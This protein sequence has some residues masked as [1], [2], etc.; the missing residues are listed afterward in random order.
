MTT[1]NTLPI[2]QKDSLIIKVLE[3]QIIRFIVGIKGKGPGIRMETGDHKK[4]ASWGRKRTAQ[5]YREKQKQLIA[6]GKFKEAQQMDIDDIHEKFGHK[7]D[8]AISEML[9]YVDKLEAEGKIDG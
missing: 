5:E 2:I 1:G 9:E 6:E 7:Y 3:D 8:D 4:T